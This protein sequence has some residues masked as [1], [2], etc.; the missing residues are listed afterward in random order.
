MIVDMAMESKNNSKDTIETCQAKKNK[1][2][3]MEY[4]KQPLGSGDDSRCRIDFDKLPAECTSIYVVV[5]VYS[6]GDFTKVKKCHLRVC[7][8]SQVHV[9][10]KDA[11]CF[12]KLD[13]K[14]YKSRGI[15]MAILKKGD[16]AWKLEA[17]ASSV[18]GGSIDSK[19]C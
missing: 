11:H 4:Q 16:K 18:G 5:N 3:G 14:G 10:F 8:S 1:C 9:G 6:G 13:L 15:W 17:C 2:A 12:G 7:D 19:D